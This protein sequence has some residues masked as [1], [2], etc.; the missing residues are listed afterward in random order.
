LKAP[1]LGEATPEV[2][3]APSELTWVRT[4]GPP[5][6]LGYDIRYNFDDPNTWYVTDNFAGVHISTDNGLT[7]QPSNTGIPPQLG[8]SGDW[9]PIFSLT[10]DPH[11]PQIIWAGT[12]KTGHIYQSTDGGRTW[13]QRDNGV[14][15]E[16]DTLTF[17]GFTV[18]PRSS[19]IVYAM[20]ETTVEALGGPAVWGSGTGGIVYKTTDG[21]LH[22]E[23]I[24]GE[25]PPSSLARYM[26]IDPRDPDV[27]YVSTGIFDRGAVGEGDPRTAPFGGLGV[28][29]SIDGG[30][31]W[32]VLG[33]D[34]GLRMLYIGSL[35]MHPENPNILLAA[36][37]HTL[38][39]PAGEYIEDLVAAGTPAPSGVYRT[40]DGGEHW[41]QV[42][43]SSPELAGEAFSS[44]D[45][46]GDGWLA[47]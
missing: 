34:N 6:G 22:W 25:P 17:R 30:E 12:D 36:A 24:W 8:P 15:I 39:G 31:T 19:D 18:D 41:T 5:G 42:L 21:G 44:V 29:K 14:T 7:W 37:G 10:V 33:E 47:N 11:A 43:I 28:L 46:G 4:G 27:L 9:I 3:S 45:S 20:G 40:T 16:H 2:I 35:F 26:W 38:E 23:K 13:K 1:P 32:R